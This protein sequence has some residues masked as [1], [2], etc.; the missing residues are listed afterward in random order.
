VFFD[1]PQ[2]VQAM[3][4][5]TINTNQKQVRRSLAL[6]MYGYNVDDE[7]RDKW[8][9]EKLAV[10]MT[11]RL[12]F[13]EHS[14]LHRHIKIEAVDAPEP[15]RLPGANRIIP[16]AAVVD[17]ILKLIT[18]NYR[19]DRDYLRSERFLSRRHRSDLPSDNSSLRD[20]YRL[21]RDRELYSVIRSYLA[22]TLDRLWNRS[23][24]GSML[25][26]AVGMRALLS[27]LGDIVGDC[28]Q[29]ESLPIA[30]ASEELVAE[31]LAF[32]KATFTAA[33][34]VDFA[35]LFFEPTGRGQARIRTTM[36]LIAGLA[37]LDDLNEGDRA[38][39]R[40]LIGNRRAHRVRRAP[41]GAAS[42]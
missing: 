31:V 4:F 27:F 9:P 42:G 29:G 16:M 14:P 23:T 22:V 20:W 25:T 30:D 24:E 7:P 18:T 17:G 2:S 40:R 35:D 38:E 32:A 8:S 3:V 34:G 12:N 36:Q 19:R 21:N 26:R 15:A 11:R 41:L 6:N 33:E 28:R 39:Y 13:D 10:F 1:M 37:K 5:A